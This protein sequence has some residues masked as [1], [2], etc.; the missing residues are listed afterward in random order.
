MRYYIDGYNLLFFLLEDEEEVSFEEIRS[1]LVT[2]IQERTQHISGSIVIVFDAHLRED[3]QDLQIFYT[4]NTKIVFTE[5]NEKADTYIIKQIEYSKNPKKD[6]VITSDK[7]LSN[8][9]RQLG[10]YTQTIAEFLKK[11][12]RKGKKKNLLLQKNIMID[13]QADIERLL[14][15]FTKKLKNK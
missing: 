4:S 11:T 9:C 3:N 7:Q 13:S 5:Q 14:K 6:I 8:I 15:I 12:I 1:Q 10:S 2:F